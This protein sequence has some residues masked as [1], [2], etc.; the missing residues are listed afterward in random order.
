VEDLLFAFQSEPYHGLLEVR[1]VAV[2][3]PVSTD[4]IREL[5]EHVEQ[6]A[7]PIDGFMSA[8]DA[9]ILLDFTGSP[10]ALAVA[11]SLADH[12]VLLGFLVDHLDAPVLLDQFDCAVQLG[13]P[14]DT[15]HL[16]DIVH[17]GIPEFIASEY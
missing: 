4:E 9:E 5:L 15:T 10:H 3:Q 6:L 17:H 16:L 14:F 11:R 13:L 1:A 8:V 2:E 7:E 12:H